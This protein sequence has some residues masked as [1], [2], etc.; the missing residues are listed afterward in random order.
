MLLNEA[1][2]Q[3]KLGYSI[4]NR[5]HGFQ[6]LVPQDDGGF[7][8]S[9]TVDPAYTFTSLDH[10]RDDWEVVGQGASF[11]EAFIP[12]PVLE[13]EFTPDGVAPIVEAPIYKEP[14]E[15]NP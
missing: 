8:L 11:L 4:R 7:R 6:M 14:V 1:L 13:S 2:D 9:G 10:V 12:N 5:D 3:V 15:E